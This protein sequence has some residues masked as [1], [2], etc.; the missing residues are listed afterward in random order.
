[1]VMNLSISDAP[2]LRMPHLLSC[3]PVADSTLP[4][5]HRIITRLSSLNPPQI[6]SRRSRA[7]VVD[8]GAADWSASPLA[9][10]AE[11]RAVA[12]GAP[13]PSSPPQRESGAQSGEG[14]EGLSAPGADAQAGARGVRSRAASLAQGTVPGSDSATRRGSGGTVGRE[15]EVGKGARPRATKVLCDGVAVNVDVCGEGRGRRPGLVSRL[16]RKLLLVRG[17]GEGWGCLGLVGCL[18]AHL[19]YQYYCGHDMRCVTRVTCAVRCV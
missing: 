14:S 7:V 11:R 19:Y 16:S 15:E 1:M 3:I 8:E 17:S 13:G 12:Q 4:C 6:P 2:W 18:A 5:L 10:P 9:S